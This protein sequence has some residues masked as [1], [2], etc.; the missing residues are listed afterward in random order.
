M[1][2]Q[3]AKGD[4]RRGRDFRHQNAQRL[5]FSGH[6]RRTTLARDYRFGRMPKIP[7]FGCKNWRNP[8]LLAE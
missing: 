1:Q 3:D 4:Q 6:F 5:E 8:Q 7:R 2:G